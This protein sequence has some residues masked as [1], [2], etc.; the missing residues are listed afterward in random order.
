MMKTINIGIITYNRHKELIRLLESL[1]KLVTDNSFTIE[2]VVV[3]DNSPDFNTQEIKSEI[4]KSKY[5]VI[6]EHEKQPGIPFA[7]NKV[8][9]LSKD[10]DF[11]AFID[12]DEIADE[13]WLFEL[14]KS[15]QMYNADIVRGPVIPKYDKAP[16][17]WLQIT[18]QR[19]RNK[20]GTI[21]KALAT[22]NVLF[23]MSIF[24]DNDAPFDIKLAQTG[25][26][27]SLLGRE[28]FKK[29]NTIIWCDEAIV[30]EFIINKRQTLPWMIQ[31][32]Y[33]GGNNYS[34]QLKILNSGSLAILRRVIISFLHII[35]GV[36]YLPLIFFPIKKRFISP[37]KF[38]EG[39][40]GIVGV[41]GLKYNE[42]KRSN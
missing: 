11:L 7:R 9:E 19:S 37:L 32:S 27:D 28:L 17:K 14:I 39:V 36:L 42:Y 41:L 24:K 23:K 18:A 34:L 26:T 8:V 30:Y 3:V 16:P 15:Q 33:R 25:G 2:N 12:D 31:R 40:G 21:M 5:S 22:G 29:G 20:T 4:N 10:V 6:H 38:A 35:E 1:N 13:N